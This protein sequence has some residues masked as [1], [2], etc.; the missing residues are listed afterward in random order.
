[1]RDEQVEQHF[2]FIKRQIA[3]LRGESAVDWEAFDAA[4]EDL[5]VTYEQMQMN[6]EATEIIQEEL[7]QERLYY[8]DLFRFSPI[9]SLIIDT[10]GMILEANQVIAQLLNVSPNYLI[11]E[12]LAMFV[13]E[14]DRSA[15][16]TYL[17]QLSQGSGIRI[18][19][20]TLCSRSG[21]P[22]MAEVHGV[23][24]RSTD[25]LIEDVRIGVY[26]LSPSQET[27]TS[28]AA[29]IAHGAVT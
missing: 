4:L 10:N 20:T 6:L 12:P 1:M 8:Q 29:A 24:A 17:S 22:V 21:E 9:A 26:A 27:V 7:I 19:Q 13:A 25:G 14:G 28:G 3:S 11:G 2:H 16:L 18:W 23:I 15:F 5:Q